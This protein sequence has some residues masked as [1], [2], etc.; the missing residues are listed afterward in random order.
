MIA[1]RRAGGTSVITVVISSGSM[2]AVPL[3]WMTRAAS[4]I[5]KPGATAARNVPALNSAIAVAKSDRVG[6]RRIRKPVIGMTTD[7]VSRKPAVSHWPTLASTARSVMSTGSATLMIVSLRMTTNVETSSTPIT[8]RSRALS[9]PAV[10][11]ALG[12]WSSTS[13]CCFTSSPTSSAVGTGRWARTPDV[14]STE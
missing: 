8:V 10:S 9:C 2:I 4:R 12:P 14:E 7:I 13:G 5:A 6:T 11:G 3:A 1:P